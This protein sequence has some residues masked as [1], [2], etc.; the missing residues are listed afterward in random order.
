MGRATASSSIIIYLYLVWSLGNGSLWLIHAQGFNARNEG[1][2][3]LKSKPIVQLEYD[4]I[5]EKY[6]QKIPNVDT[7]DNHVR[8]LWHLSSLSTKRLRLR[9]RLRLRYLPRSSTDAIRVVHR[10]ENNPPLNFRL[11]TSL[12][13][14][15]YTAT[16]HTTNNP[17]VFVSVRECSCLPEDHYPKYS[18]YCPLELDN[19]YIPQ[20]G[21]TDCLWRKCT[22]TAFDSKGLF[23]EKRK[24]VHGRFLPS[25]PL[26]FPKNTQSPDLLSRG[27]NI[28][29][30]CSFYMAR[31]HHHVYPVSNVLVSTQQGKWA[32]LYWFTSCVPSWNEAAVTWMLRNRPE[33]SRAMI[34]DWVNRH[35]E[36]ILRQLEVEQHQEQVQDQEQQRNDRPLDVSLSQDDEE[37]LR[38]LQEQHQHGRSSLILKTRI[39][40]TI[41][42]QTDD[43]FQ[44]SIDKKDDGDD[45]VGQPPKMMSPDPSS[46]HN[47]DDTE[48]DH[49][50][51]ESFCTI[52]FGPLQTGDRVG[53]FPCQ[54]TFHVDC[55]KVWLK[56]RAVCPLC[57]R[58]DVVVRR[59]D[60]N[61]TSNR[62][63]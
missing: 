61:G 39:Y 52:C 40:K 58:T 54:H 18:F 29:L 21:S 60:N 14:N 47:F 48:N 3:Y 20:C 16:N 25:L 1:H 9:L 56:K 44:I 35:R 38:E 33:Q 50:V 15:N 5:V 31:R 55:L 17:I 43:D 63:D 42:V 12:S 32:I 46:S 6:T 28:P 8:Q 53:N 49:L 24:K 4:P 11:L 30:V 22:V 13:S 27:Q 51:D 23:L 34:R 62:S 45:P 37:L 7:S 59:H 26:F 2:C 10:N 41:T 36:H 19:C 57:L